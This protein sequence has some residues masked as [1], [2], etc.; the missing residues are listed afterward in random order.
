MVE[1]FYAKFG[2]PSCIGFRD[3]VW[4]NKKTDRHINAAEKPTGATTVGMGS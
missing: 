1:H 3:I 2:N 4:K